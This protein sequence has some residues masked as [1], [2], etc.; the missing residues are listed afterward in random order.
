[1]RENRESDTGNPCRR[2]VT[3]C[4]TLSRLNS[5]I[6]MTHSCSGII[7]APSS[8]CDKWNTWISSPTAVA[9]GL[10]GLCPKK[11]LLCYAA[12]PAG[13]SIM[14]NPEAYYAWNMP[15]VRLWIILNFT[16]SRAWQL[17]N[18]ACTCINEMA[19]ATSTAESSSTSTPQSPQCPQA[20]VSLL[21]RLKCNNLPI[22]I[23]INFLGK[24]ERSY[25]AH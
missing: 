3:D 21:E 9:L 18:H 7:M 8:R 11:A 1:M 17:T 22:I 25:Y 16:T 12:M 2:I 6:G 15:T 19:T 24:S 13:R 4:D 14:L 23:V 20:R 10:G 5:A